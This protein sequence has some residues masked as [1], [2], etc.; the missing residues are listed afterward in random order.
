M[1]CGIINAGTTAMG[2]GVTYAMTGHVTKVG[3]NIFCGR[4]LDDQ[5]S[6]SAS[7]SASSLSTAAS[8]VTTLFPPL[9]TTLAVLYSILF[10]WYYVST[11]ANSSTRTRTRDS[12]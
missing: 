1:A 7:S 6:V 5:T 12:S 11:T 9:G 3:T 8:F 4:I 2:L 10:R